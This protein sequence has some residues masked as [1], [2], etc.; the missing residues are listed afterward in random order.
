M[1]ASILI[2][3]LFSQ[4]V[5]TDDRSGYIQKKY[6][7][8]SGVCFQYVSRDGS[9]VKFPSF[10]G[11][12]N[13]WIVEGLHTI[14]TP[15]EGRGIFIL[16]LDTGES[17]VFR[18]QSDN[19]DGGSTKYK[20]ANWNDSVISVLTDAGQLVFVRVAGNSFGITYSEGKRF[21]YAGGKLTAI[22]YG[23]HTVKPEYE[24]NGILTAFK[25]GTEKLKTNIAAN[26]DL[27]SV[28]QSGKTEMYQYSP[29]DSSVAMRR[30]LLRVD[31]KVIRIGI[32]KENQGVSQKMD[33]M[34]MIDGH[35]I[36][37][38]K[39]DLLKKEK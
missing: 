37:V 7:A 1:I 21:D 22:K 12:G 8:E 25:S 4:I 30:T 2:S 10:L 38:F 26:G 17:I 32:K 27:L 33:S 20:S 19:Y 24:K 6:I 3:A 14:E 31:D 28:L 11:F 13:G 39:R 35:D 36:T 9:S 29:A 5:L 15:I 34:V 23:D 16:T 18:K